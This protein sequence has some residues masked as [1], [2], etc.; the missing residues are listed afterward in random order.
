MVVGCGRSTVRCEP[1]VSGAIV[2]L[3]VK[4]CENRRS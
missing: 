2:P 1:C 4:S 3:A